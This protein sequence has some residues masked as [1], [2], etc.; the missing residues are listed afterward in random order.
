MHLPPFKK[1][2]VKHSSGIPIKGIDRA[3]GN[4]EGNEQRT[5]ILSVMDS[6]H[7]GKEDYLH[8]C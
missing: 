4:Q 6:L 8:L 3:I 1:Q 2:K 5:T 7:S